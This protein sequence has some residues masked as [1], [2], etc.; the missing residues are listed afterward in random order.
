MN[1]DKALVSK[2][3]LW[4]YQCGNCGQWWTIGDPKCSLREAITCPRCE[5]VLQVEVEFPKEEKLGAEEK[6]R[7]SLVD[8]K[9]PIELDSTTQRICEEQQ[10]TDC[11]KATLQQKVFWEIATHEP[12][13]K[14]PER[15]LT[16]RKININQIE[17]IERVD[18]SRYVLQMPN[19][20]IILDTKSTIYKSIGVNELLEYLD[21]LTINKV[22]K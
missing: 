21:E 12:T 11:G 4:H 13:G 19:Q 15:A 20:T 2:E 16:T 14:P 7:R 8:D 9:S 18:P 1:K 6:E 17:S 22:D 3:E 10:S 5:Q